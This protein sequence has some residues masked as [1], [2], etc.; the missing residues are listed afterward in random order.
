ME[1]NG[2][3]AKSR[4]YFTSSI[5]NKNKLQ[6]VVEEPVSRGSQSEVSIKHMHHRSSFGQTPGFTS[7]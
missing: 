1:S 4:N 6:T 5:T 3:G 2:A 7:N